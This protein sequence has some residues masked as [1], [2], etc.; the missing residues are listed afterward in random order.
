M[1]RGIKCISVRNTMLVIAATILLA[2]IPFVNAQTSGKTSVSIQIMVYVPSILNLTLDFSSSGIAQ[3]VAYLGDSRDVR[4][5]GFELKSNSVVPLGAA[6]VISNLSS[7][8]SIVVQSMNGCAL[9]NQDSEGTVN[10]DLILGGIPAMRQGDSFKLN[11]CGTT[12]FEG[13]VLPVSIAL[14]NVPSN[15]APG[16]YADNLLFNI[17][18]N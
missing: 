9:K 10:Y 16:L 14:G 17:M 11:C 4:G 5:K 7:G 1:R 12:P 6:H 13:R 18:A 2:S 8:Y 3:L 15:A